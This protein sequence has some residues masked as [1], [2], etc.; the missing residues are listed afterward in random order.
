MSGWWCGAC[1]MPCDWRK[2]NPLLTLQIGDTADDQIVLP[3]YSA[4]GGEC[5]NIT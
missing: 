4:L 5:D 1:G 3:A 2:P